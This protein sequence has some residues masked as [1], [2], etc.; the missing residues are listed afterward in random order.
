MKRPTKRP[1]EQKVEIT[2]RDTDGGRGKV[3]VHFNAR[4][5]PQERT[6]NSPALNLGLRLK[7]IIERHFEMLCLPL[8]A[9]PGEPGY[10]SPA[11]APGNVTPLILPGDPGFH[12]P[13]TKLDGN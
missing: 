3:E 13:T 5:A 8:G 6:T 7:A 11:S 12:Q 2:I 1:K 10:A 9:L 4:P